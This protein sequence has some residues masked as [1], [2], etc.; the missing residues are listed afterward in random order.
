MPIEPICDSTEVACAINL[1][2]TD[3]H[4]D[5]FKTYNLAKTFFVQPRADEQLAARLCSALSSALRNWG[6]EIRKA[7]TLVS[8]N[9]LAAALLDPGIFDHLRQLH[10]T[11]LRDVGLSLQG[12]REVSA[13][14][15]VR[16]VSI[17]ELI[18]SLI[19]A[20]HRS[21]FINNT[22]VTYPMKALLLLT[23]FMPAYDSQ[24]RRGLTLCGLGGFGGTR[25]LVETNPRR[26]SAKKVSS[27]PYL[28]GDCFKR[29][30]QLFVEG[31][32]S[33]SYPL[34]AEIPGRLFDILLFVQGSTRRTLLAFNNGD[35]SRWYELP[36]G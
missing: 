32:R 19:G 14:L 36:D 21:L 29:H 12:R 3:Y 5:F 9:Q 2:R 34:L 31:A 17:D 4:T 8:E 35:P 33:S 27:L 11:S 13:A 7:P 1:F 6:A 15:A 20:V 28:L 22:N 24:V 23:G 30:E 18:A 25:F 26:A 10:S 16:L